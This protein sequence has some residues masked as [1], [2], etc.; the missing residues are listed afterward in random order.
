[1]RDI[2]DT[3]TDTNDDDMQDANLLHLDNPR[4][5]INAKHEWRRCPRAAC[6]RAR[7]CASAA[8]EPCAL[9][10]E[11]RPVSPERESA[12]LAALHKALKRRM[13]ELD[14]EGGEA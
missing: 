14:M 8:W 4:K 10:F 7:T 13:A 9:K 12:A 6:R 11:R 1:M 5:A 3:D 2:P